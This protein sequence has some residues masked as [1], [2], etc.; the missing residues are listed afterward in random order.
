M[1]A[2]VIVARILLGLPLSVFGANAI[3]RFLGEPQSFGSE[4]DAFLTA[5]DNAGYVESLRGAVE[6]ICG[7]LFLSGRYVPLA[8][9]VFLPVLANILGFHLFL[10]SQGLGFA[11]TL[12]ICEVFLLWAYRDS[13]RPLLK[14]KTDP[15]AVRG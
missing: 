11:M 12:A 14:A 4:A 13:F 8:A 2:V 9:A 15:S 5:L 7:L 1:K 10:S 6:L 3:F